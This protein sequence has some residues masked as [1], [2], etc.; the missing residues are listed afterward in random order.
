MR[1]PTKMGKFRGK[2]M[3][4]ILSESSIFPRL[5]MMT[6]MMMTKMMMTKMMMTK[7]MIHMPSQC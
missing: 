5:M 7:M 4:S 2:N 1:I 3:S 6:K